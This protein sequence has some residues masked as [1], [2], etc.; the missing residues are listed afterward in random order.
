MGY[1]ANRDF[2]FA[3]GQKELYNFSITMVMVNKFLGL[4]TVLNAEAI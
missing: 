1:K 4:V 2:R 3:D